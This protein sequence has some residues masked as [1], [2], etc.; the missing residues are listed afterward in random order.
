MAARPS[1]P[2]SAPQAEPSPGFAATFGY[3]SGSGRAAR[4]H[5][6]V[7]VSPDRI[8]ALPGEDIAYR[9]INPA[10]AESMNRWCHVDMGQHGRPAL[11]SGWR[12][13]GQGSA[14]VSGGDG[15]PG[16]GLL[17]ASGSRDACADRGTLR[18]FASH[19]DNDNDFH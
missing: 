4:Q 13:A 3:T 11:D 15:H 10:D 12:Q 8:A 1:P 7:V 9:W 17:V 5:A 2:H 18:R 6:F 16:V 14:H 19:I